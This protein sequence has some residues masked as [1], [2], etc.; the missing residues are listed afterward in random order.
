[1]F[2]SHEARLYNDEVEKDMYVSFSLR[3][4]V[5]LLKLPTSL[6]AM[7]HPRCVGWGEMGLDY[8]YDNSPRPLQQSVFTRQ[9]QLA[10][11]LGKSLTIH[12]REAEE[13]TERILKQEV[14]RDHKVLSSFDSL[15]EQVPYHFLGVDPYPLLY[16]FPSFRATIARSFSESPY[17]NNRFVP[18][19]NVETTNLMH[20]HLLRWTGVITYS[21]NQ[22]TS[23]TVREMASTNPS[24]L[25]IL[26]ET[27]SPYMVPA[28]IYPSLPKALKGK[29]PIC[30][31]AM[32]PWTAEFVAGILG[33]PTSTGTEETPVKAE[34]TIESEWDT[35]KV[36]RTARDNAK[37]VYGV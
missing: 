14:P 26:L 11:K 17:R 33:S 32:I 20:F 4:L 13:D 3:S 8:H 18:N 25:R 10:V 5:H 22:D 7:A 21:T 23:T 15:L 12:T 30:H 1:M 19:H 28:N 37:F 36:M 35:D 31:T 29:L 2:L 16:R 24:K 6:Q 34:A 27:D 9:L